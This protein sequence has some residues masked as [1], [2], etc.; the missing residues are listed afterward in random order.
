MEHKVQPDQ[1]SDQLDRAG[2]GHKPAHIQA[3]PEH[4]EVE[5]DEEAIGD[6][7]HLRGETFRAPDRRDHETRAK[8]GDQDARPPLLGKPREQEQDEQRQAQIER[9]VTLPG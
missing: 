9:P 4:D 1:A 7:A 8:A 3:C 6:A 2:V 5:R